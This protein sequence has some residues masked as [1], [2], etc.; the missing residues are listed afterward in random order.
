MIDLKR[1]FTEEDNFERLKWIEVENFRAFKHVK[2]DEFADINIFIGKN[3]TG[4]STLLEA[5]YLNLTKGFADIIFRDPI[6]YIFYRRGIEPIRL[7]ASEM[8]IP[9]YLSYL[10]RN[11]EKRFSKF[12][13]NFGEYGYKLLYENEITDYI[14]KNIGI[15]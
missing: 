12:I 11:Y 2:I 13:S 15:Y 4:K 7:F 5:I 3:N 14:L 9:F 1:T 10:F 8:E 6:R